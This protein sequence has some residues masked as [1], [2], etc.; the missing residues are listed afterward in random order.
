MDYFSLV[1]L[2]LFSQSVDYASIEANNE[3][4]DNAECSIDKILDLEN[5]PHNTVEAVLD[6]TDD[7][8]RRE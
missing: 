1:L 6:I 5:G 8:K 2:V 4:N 3:A 7:K